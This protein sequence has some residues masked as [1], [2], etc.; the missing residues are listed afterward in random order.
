MRCPDKIRYKTRLKALLCALSRVNDGAPPLRAY[1]C[2][3]CKSWHLTKRIASGD[4]E[5]VVR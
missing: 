3:T 2:P 5:G 4:D 1:R